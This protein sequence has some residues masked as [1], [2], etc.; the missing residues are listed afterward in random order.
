MKTY[1]EILEKSITINGMQDLQ[2][3]TLFKGFQGKLDLKSWQ[4][5]SEYAKHVQTGVALKLIKASK[6]VPKG[7]GGFDD[8]EHQN[9]VFITLT[10]NGLMVAKQFM[11]Q[12]KI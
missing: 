5:D 8:W 9:Q 11:D 12:G 3:R 10:K 1:R 7:L 4:T 6:K 2:L